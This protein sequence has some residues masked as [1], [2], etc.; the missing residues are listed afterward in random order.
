MVI[1]T[2]YLELCRKSNSNRV[3][4]KIN[5]IMK[6]ILFV[7]LLA[8]GSLAFYNFSLTDAPGEKYPTYLPLETMEVLKKE[9]VKTVENEALMSSL[10]TKFTS[11]FDEVTAVHGQYNEDDG[12]YY[13]V[14][15][16][17]DGKAKIELLKANATDIENETYTYIDFSNMNLDYAAAV[18]C[19]RGPLNPSHPF[20]CPSDCDARLYQ[21]LGYVCGVLTSGGHCVEK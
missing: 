2:N 9:H 10:A 4:P 11:L 3:C 16:K 1:L 15:G 21:C 18:F 19:T 13:V 17:Q 14:F 6:K 5:F 8:I 12:H 7:C 20:T